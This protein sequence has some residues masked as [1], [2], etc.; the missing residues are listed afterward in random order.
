MGAALRG[1]RT[2]AVLLA[3]ALALAAASSAVLR[4]RAEVQEWDCPPAPAS[5]ARP[6]LVAGFP[7]P[8][9]SDHHGI[10]T[11]GSVSLVGALLGEDRF[12]ARAFGADVGVYLVLLAAARAAAARRAGAAA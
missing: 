4:T 1:L 12:H 11:V 10:S 3:G 5:C 2:P 9:V 8:Y 7:F 6:V